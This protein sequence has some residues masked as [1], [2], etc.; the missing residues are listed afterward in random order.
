[1]DEEIYYQIE[2][3]LTMKLG[4]DPTEEEII[5]EYSSVCDAM[6]ESYKDRQYNGY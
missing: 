6:Y 1:M 3:R 2:E 4:R 5:D